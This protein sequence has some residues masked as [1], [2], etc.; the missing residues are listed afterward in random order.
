M[1]RMSRRY[2]FIG[3]L[4]V[5]LGGCVSAPDA[6]QSAS[7]ALVV[8]PPAQT[9]MR[10]DASDPLTCAAG[11]NCAGTEVQA[12]ETFAGTVFA[13]LSNWMESDPSIYPQSV[14]AQVLRYDEPNHVW[15]PTPALPG[16]CGAQV[17]WEQVNDLQTLTVGG[18]DTLLVAT[19]PNRDNLAACPSLRGTVFRGDGTN[20]WT[21]TGLGAQLAAWY[22]DAGTTAEVRYLTVNTL[23]TGCSAAEP[24]V[25]AAV[26][27]QRPNNPMGGPS[28]VT[29]CAPSIWR[30]QVTGGVLTWPTSP[31]LS[32]DGT[33]YPIASRIVSMH[34]SQDGTMLIGS[35]IPKDYGTQSFPACAGT[36]NNQCP[37][38][39]LLRRSPAGGWTVPWRGPKPG[40]AGPFEFEVRGI[41]SY[42]SGGQSLVWF[43]TNPRGHLRRMSASGATVLESTLRDA[44]N[45]NA[46]YGYQILQTP[47]IGQ[48]AQLIVASEGC[49]A[50][51]NGNA[52]GFVRELNTAAPTS[53]GWQDVSLPAISNA[54]APPGVRK[55]SVRW[56]HTSPFACTDLFVGTTDM[57]SDPGT[58]TARV[59]EVLNPIGAPPGACP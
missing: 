34:T 47:F 1:F 29:H 43:F 45:C 23:A 39:A 50:P 31:E 27:I 15:H 5:T 32:L 52:M 19:T 54:G 53:G 51:A 28:C 40:A 49:M 12:L 30:G 37:R 10:Y 8:I 35:A 25:F 42:Q 58:R 11:A 59:F 56:L 38:S 44:F 6:T 16:A 33:S 57:N 36:G 24:C 18:G 26:G 21:D 48:T 4:T 14:S 55:D 20:A 13:G 9:L 22:A 17:A 7:S 3:A 41:T 2:V 46:F